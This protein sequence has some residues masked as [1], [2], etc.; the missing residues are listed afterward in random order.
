MLFFLEDCS[1]TLQKRKPDFAASQAT[2]ELIR[3]NW[4]GSIPLSRLFYTAG[5]CQ[6]QHRSNVFGSNGMYSRTKICRL[7][8]N[9]LCNRWIVTW[10]GRQNS[11]QSVFEL[12]SASWAICRMQMMLRMWPIPIVAISGDDSWL[13][14][15]VTQWATEWRPRSPISSVACK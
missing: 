4:T 2:T 13:R 10:N 7:F 12:S 8:Q 3:Y 15:P 5:W 14:L 6:P 1:W 11:D 9:S